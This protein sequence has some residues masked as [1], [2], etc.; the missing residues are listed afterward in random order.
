[1]LTRPNVH[2]PTYPVDRGQNAFF[3]AL[4]GMTLGVIGLSALLW[5]NTMFT[6]MQE[7]SKTIDE[8]KKGVVETN[9]RQRIAFETALGEPGGLSPERFMA[10]YKNLADE[11]DNAKKDLQR[12]SSINQLLTDKSDS[13]AKSL[14]SLEK[15]YEIASKY[16]KAAEEL[17]K[18]KP[19]Y[20]ELLAEK[21][22]QFKKIGELEG[23]LDTTEGKRAKDLTSKYTSTWYW[24][25]AGWALSFVL[26]ALMVVGYSVLRFP[27]EEE[28][29]PTTAEGPTHRIV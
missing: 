27:P 4:L 12:Q 14:A 9:E 26:L 1:M 21:K 16:E 24:M 28:N 18:I 23:L 22:D 5:L 13:M 25:I 15:K 20:E 8:L 3:F 29:P 10:R 7:Q 2:Q 17:D 11:R 6:Q 19:K